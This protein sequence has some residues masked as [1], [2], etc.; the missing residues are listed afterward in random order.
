M[1]KKE[2]IQ[3]YIIHDS[4]SNPFRSMSNAEDAWKVLEDAGYADEDKQD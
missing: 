3:H 1:D 4:E 2:F